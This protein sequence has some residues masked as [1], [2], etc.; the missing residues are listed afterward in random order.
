MGIDIHTI[1]VHGGGTTTAQ[2]DRLGMVMLQ[3]VPTSAGAGA[4]SAVVTPV[5]GL[6]LPVSGGY[7]VQVEPNQDAAAFVTSK[8]QSGFSVSLSP[9]L[10]ANTLASGTMDIMVVF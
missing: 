7:I 5:A 6:D 3:N 1:E 9:R 4:G 10:A 2:P 8:T